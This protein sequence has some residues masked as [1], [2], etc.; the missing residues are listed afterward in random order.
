MRC[1]SVRDSHGSE[2][3]LKH[4][5]PK[6]SFPFLSMSGGHRN[7]NRCQSKPVAFSISISMPDCNPAVPAH[8]SAGSNTPFVSM[9]GAHAASAAGAAHNVVAAAKYHGCSH[10]PQT[11]TAHAAT[12]DPPARPYHT[13]HNSAALQSQYK[14]RRH[15]G[16]A[17]P[18]LPSSHPPTAR[19][20]ALPPPGRRRRGARADAA[21]SCVSFKLSPSTRPSGRAHTVCINYTYMCIGNPVGIAVLSAREIGLLVHAQTCTN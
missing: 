2:N 1:R 21:V 10:A 13:A 20:A 12:R 5:R 19:T 16:H 9:D 7:T 6:M 8:I 15:D 17:R 14:A 4:L 18:A 3:G 11:R